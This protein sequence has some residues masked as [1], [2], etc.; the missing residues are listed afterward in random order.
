MSATTRAWETAVPFNKAA[1]R[2]GSAKLRAEYVAARNLSAMKNFEQ[3]AL[4]MRDTG[5]NILD[6]LSAAMAGPQAIFAARQKATDALNAQLLQALRAG[7]LIAYGFE[8]P[9]GLD[10]RPRLLSPDLWKSVNLP[11]GTE[12]REKGLHLIELRVA[13][14]AAKRESQGL[15]ATSPGH[16]QPPGRPG[17]APDIRAAFEALHAQGKI[18]AAR[19]ARSHFAMVRDWLIEHRPNMATSPKHIKDETIRRHFSP[20]FNAL[21][22]NH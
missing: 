19:P 11:K 22:E 21:S 13:T 9:R 15:P 7:D 4:E 14:R 10:D 20:L 18:D 6:N 2:F 1:Y 5:K 16:S 3:K 8:A 12:L 17:V